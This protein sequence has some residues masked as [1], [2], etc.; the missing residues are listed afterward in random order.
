MSVGAIEVQAHGRFFFLYSVILIAET[1]GF[2]YYI[3]FDFHVQKKLLKR[4]LRMLLQTREFKRGLSES[5][6]SVV[7]CSDVE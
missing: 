4:G 7:K 3:V 6:R 5:K 1:F 2:N